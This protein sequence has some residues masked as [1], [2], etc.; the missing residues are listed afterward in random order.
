MSKDVNGPVEVEPVR[1][2]ISPVRRGPSPARFLCVVAVAVGAIGYGAW[3]GGYHAGWLEGRPTV[4]LTTLPVDQGE[5][6]AE[7]VENG[8]LESANNAAVKCQVEALVGLTGWQTGLGAVATPK[9]SAGG[10]GTPAEPTGRTAA[11]LRAGANVDMAKVSTQVSTTV[12]LGGLKPG[13]DTSTS[14]AAATTGVTTLDKPTI[15]SFSYSVPPYTI[16]RTRISVAVAQKM[17]WIDPSMNRGGSAEKPGSTRIIK[18]VDEGTK[19]KAGDI[20]CELDSAKFQDELKAQQI[21]YL[22]AR[23]WVEQA[24]SI[25]GVN[26]ITMREYQEGV[27]PQDVQ[28]V[29]QYTTACRTEEDRARQ[30]YEW[31]KAT[32]IRGFRSATQLQADALAWQQAEFQL[33]E[34]EHMANRLERYT[35]PRL[36]TSLKAKIEAIKSDLLAQEAAFQLETDRMKRLETA[37]ANCTI[38]APRDGMVVYHN[39][40]NMWGRIDNMIREGSVVREGQTLIDL[41]DPKHMRVRARINESKVASV[42]TGQK[43]WVSIDAFTDRPLLGT[44]SEVTPIPTGAGG[45]IS[46]VKIYYA[47][48]EL[49]G[50]GYDGLRPGLSAEV[51]FLVKARRRVTRVPLEAI[52]WVEGRP[53]AAAV[54]GKSEGSSGAPRGGPGHRSAWEWRSVALGQSDRDFAEVITGLAPGERVVSDPDLLPP[55]RPNHAGPTVADTSARPR[56]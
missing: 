6:T 24:R 48:I 50:Q 51:S 41:P 56:G 40:P 34:S 37:V 44:V 7:V 29:H 35:A 15:R 28:L 18:I 19:V 23:S 11:K 43:A 17:G 2:E 49:D 8:T 20:L 45:P 39:P 13:T 55:P 30:N 21:R 1:L 12:G 14:A 22:Q 25:L 26:L 31:S 52:R 10:I 42:H 4:T 46:D 33:R 5:M 36:I 38:R 9:N 16:L 32:A 3:R 27:Y 47:M 53:F 54:R